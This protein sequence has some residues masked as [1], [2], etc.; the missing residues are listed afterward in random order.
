MQNESS[1]GF[2]LFRKRTP[3]CSI[4]MKRPEGAPF[5]SAPELWHRPDQM[6][7]RRTVH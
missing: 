2:S 5:I 1:T 6:R 3:T 4:R 7:R